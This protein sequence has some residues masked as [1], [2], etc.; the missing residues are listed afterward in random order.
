MI[1]AF[2]RRYVALSGQQAPNAETSLSH[3]SEVMRMA[4]QRP[5]GDQASALRDYVAALPEV[6]RRCREVVA[7]ICAMRDTPV[8]EQQVESFCA[9]LALRDPDYNPEELVNEVLSWRPPVMRYEG[10]VREEARERADEEAR[11]AIAGGGGGGSAA[12]SSTGSLTGGA[13]AAMGAGLQFAVPAA[14]RRERALAFAA[15]WA[16]AAGRRMDAA[17]FV[18]HYL[19]ADGA[20][21]GEP[22]SVIGSR[23]A[24]LLEAQREA[25]S[26]AADAHLFYT[27]TPLTEQ[28]FMDA[29]MD[30]YA[31]ADFQATLV[32]D[33]ICGDVYRAKMRE[34]IHSE[35]ER[36]FGVRLHAEDLERAFAVVQGGRLALGSDELVRVLA[37]VN[38]RLE[39][40]LFHVTEAY[41]AVLRRDPE[42]EEVRENVGRF[43]SG[44]G[45]D[46]LQLPAGADYAPAIAQLMHELV[47]CIEFH[48]VVKLRLGEAAVRCG[49]SLRGRRVYDLLRS[50]LSEKAAAPAEMLHD[51]TYDAAVRR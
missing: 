9:R 34:R 12:V 50:V 24:E 23:A 51:A 48:D 31:A 13:A 32:A 8:S 44:G 25:F 36:I 26:K 40:V 30:R 33:I 21:G 7:P 3:V 37:R 29:Y 27:E 41:N 16:A 46:P 42:E 38:E 11:A 35:Y 14:L 19:L 45:G 22:A 39:E 18:Q 6:R 2:K 10:D 43:L 15:A 1:T 28:Q 17:E 47:T 20:C 4:A 49:V 5:D